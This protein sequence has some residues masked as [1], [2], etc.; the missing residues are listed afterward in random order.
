MFKTI[1]VLRI[2]DPI[3]WYVS[4]ICPELY[5]TISLLAVILNKNIRWYTRDVSYSFLALLDWELM[6][7]NFVS[8]ITMETA[9]VLFWFP[10]P[11]SV[12]QVLHVLFSLCCSVPFMCA[13]IKTLLLAELF[14]LNLLSVVIQRKD[15]ISVSLLFILLSGVA[16]SEL[17]QNGC[18]HYLNITFQ[19]VFPVMHFFSYL[20]LCLIYLWAKVERWILRSFDFLLW[21]AIFTLVLSWQWF[22]GQTC[23][24]HYTLL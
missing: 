6:I 18:I 23:R 11:L 19:P 5:Y 14:L 21:R 24:H 16:Y 20:Y 7:H 8:L 22:I 17:L 12:V 4:C 15:L 10:C 2:T 9:S 1:K 3:L 13:G